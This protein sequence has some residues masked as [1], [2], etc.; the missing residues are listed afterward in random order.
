MS[1]TQQPRQMKGLSRIGK[2]RAMQKT[3]TS[4]C[5]VEFEVQSGKGQFNSTKS[6]TH[7]TNGTPVVHFE[8]THDKSMQNP[9]SSHH[10]VMKIFM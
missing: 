9:K 3:G 6:A 8:S 7:E 1:Q 10:K 4:P 5:P 2:A